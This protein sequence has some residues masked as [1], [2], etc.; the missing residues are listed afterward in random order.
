MTDFLD[1]C[2]AAIRVQEKSIA[3]TLE[4]IDEI[5]I[6]LR[7]KRRIVLVG[8]GDSYAVSEYGK[9]TFLAV[10]LNALSISPTEI[11]DIPLDSKCLIIGVTA[12]GRSLSTIDAIQEARKKGAEVVVL[13]DNKGGK[14]VEDATEVWI[15]KAHVDSYNVSPASP[16]TTAMAYLLKVAALQNSSIQRDLLSDIDNLIGNGLKMLEWAEIEGAA[17]SKM[18]SV[19]RPL[20]MISDGPNYVA[21]QIGMM[22]FDEFSIIKGLVA[23]REDFCHHHVFGI[24]EMDQAVLISCSPITTDDER[25]MNVLLGVLKMKA[26]HLH[27]DLGLKTSLAQAIPNTIALQIASHRVVRRIN[28][29]LSGFKLPHAKAFKIY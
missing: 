4:S 15:T 3:D 14:A 21:A 22:K 6:N 19:G 25:Y 28:P 20:Y 17:I 2:Y 24:D 16:T 23:L 26:Y 1:S 29:H 27:N 18:V 8:A 9:W 12:S 5:G 10:D 13:T 7:T 11:M